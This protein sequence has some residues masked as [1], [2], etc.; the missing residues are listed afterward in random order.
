MDHNGN[1]Y[2]NTLQIYPKIYEFDILNFQN[3]LIY[4]PT[5]YEL[6]SFSVSSYVDRVDNLKLVH[7]SK[8]NILNISFLLK[9][10]NDIPTLKSI[11]FDLTDN[12]KIYKNSTYRFTTLENNNIF[13]LN[14][15]TTFNFYLSS[16]PTSLV[17]DEIII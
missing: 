9:D 11:D 10:Q 17:D 12:T 13:Y 8:N 6:S 15:P 16:T 2:D 7:S 3:N 14:I 1:F 5:S 4:T